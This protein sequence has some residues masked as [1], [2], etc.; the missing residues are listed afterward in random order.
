MKIEADP[1]R[2]QSGA[3]E[4]P[5]RPASTPVPGQPASD[6]TPAPAG[7]QLQISEAA[8]IVRAAMEGAS[9][10]PSIRQDVVDRMRALLDDGR[11]GGDT[12]RLAEAIID[13][14]LTTP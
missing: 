14:W 5:I 3:A 11:I 13:R 9:S 6:A 12:S 1:L 2:M 7:D 4:R 10:L 8:Q